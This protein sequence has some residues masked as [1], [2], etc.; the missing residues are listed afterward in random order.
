LKAV[1]REL[2]KCKLDVVRVQ[3]VGWDRGGTALVDGCKF[4]CENGVTDH[5]LGTGFFV[6]K[7]IISAVKKTELISDRSCKQEVLGVVFSMCM[8]QLRIKIII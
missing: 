5:H 3:E 6:Y 8:P 1:A 7:G 4:F 2:A